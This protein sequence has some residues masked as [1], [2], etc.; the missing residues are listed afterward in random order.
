MKAAGD[1][2]DWDEI[3]RFDGG[4]GWI[5]YPDEAMRRASHALVE[6]GDVWVLD[7]VDAPG[8]DDLFADLGT[9]AGVVVLLDRHKRDA[10]A[11]AER[12]DVSVHVP[13]P[14]HGA[15]EE[16][17]AP[18]EQFRHDLADTSYAAHEVIDRVGWREAALYSEEQGVLFV[19]EAVGNAPYFTVGDEPIGVHPM[20]RFRPPRGLGRLSSDHLLFGHGEGVHEDAMAALQ[21]ALD[22]ARARLPALS[23]QN[24]KAMLGS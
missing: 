6:D 10:A 13:H 14:L 22:G 23:W 12:H 17:D 21:A 24:L 20:V 9:V 8:V 15:A 5:A 19:P 7:P 4:V 2:A 1:A 18:V 16:I 11:I 3:D